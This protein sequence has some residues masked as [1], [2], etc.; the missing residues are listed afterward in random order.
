M[1]NSLGMGPP[2]QMTP[3]DRVNQGPRRGRPTAADEWTSRAHR[4]KHQNGETSDAEEFQELERLVQV[5]F[6]VFD[7]YVL[8]SFEFAM[9]THTNEQAQSN[10]SLL[11]HWE[12]CS[13]QPRFSLFATMKLRFGQQLTR[14]N[15]EFRWIT[16]LKKPRLKIDQ[17]CVRSMH[18]RH[19]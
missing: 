11:G 6:C 14:R 5:F 9:R 7:H 1:G 16:L 18:V 2:W 13:R 8:S 12:S 3:T 17:I 19:S 10:T 15:S 4:W